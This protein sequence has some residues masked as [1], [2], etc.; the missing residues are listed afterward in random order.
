[1]KTTH[2][3]LWSRHL[4]QIISLLLLLRSACMKFRKENIHSEQE[5]KKV[6]IEGITPSFASFLIHISQIYRTCLTL[7]AACVSQCKIITVRFKVPTFTFGTVFHQRVSLNLSIWSL[8]SKTE[9]NDFWLEEKHPIA[10]SCHQ[11]SLSWEYVCYLS[12]S[13]CDNS[14]ST[15]EMY[16]VTHLCGCSDGNCLPCPHCPYTLTLTEPR[17]FPKRCLS[18]IGTCTLWQVQTWTVKLAAVDWCEKAQK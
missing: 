5:G 17:L 16:L 18:A 6:I 12:Y 13:E 4:V 11:S 14:Q 8:F 3:F 7:P 10:L 9:C 1:M 15:Y 2:I